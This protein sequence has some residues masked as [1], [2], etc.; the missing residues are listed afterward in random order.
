MENDSM[1][2]L[3]KAAGGGAMAQ[4]ILFLC[5]ILLYINRRELSGRKEI[6][7]ETMSLMERSDAHGRM[8]KNLQLGHEL[9]GLQA[10]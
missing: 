10:P 3:G 8:L 7:F 9:Q 1:E 4:L 5:P 6:M 2:I